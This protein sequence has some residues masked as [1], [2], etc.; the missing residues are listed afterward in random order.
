[1]AISK[2]STKTPIKSKKLQIKD[3]EGHQLARIEVTDIKT[4]AGK[5]ICLSVKSQSQD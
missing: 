5:V 2:K 3:L 1:M 4:A